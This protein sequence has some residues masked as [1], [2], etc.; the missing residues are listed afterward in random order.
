MKESISAV[1]AICKLITGDP[2]ATL[3]KALKEIENKVE[4][5]PALKKAF[6]N[7]Y[8]YSSNEKGIRHSLLDEPNLDSEDARFMLVSCSAFINYL[9]LKSSKVGI[10]L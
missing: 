9:I 6:V 5:R 10:E 7:L 4:L 1:E 2:K 3:G 8:G